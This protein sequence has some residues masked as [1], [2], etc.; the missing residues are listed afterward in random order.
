MAS[1]PKSLVVKWN[2]LQAARWIKQCIRDGNVRFTSHF[3]DEA[4]KDS[5]STGDATE[6]ILEGLAA[7]W[8]PGEDPAT[9]LPDMRM[10]FMLERRTKSLAVV[11]AVSDHDPDCIVITTW[12]LVQKNERR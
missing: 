7:N 3:F 6:C 2:K 12:K 4:R 11:V 10:R 5:I 9:S 1:K 8:E